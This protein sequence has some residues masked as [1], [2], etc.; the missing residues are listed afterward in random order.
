MSAIAPDG[1]P[2][3]LYALLPER[4]EGELVAQAVARGA[5]ILELGCGTGRITRQL[6]ARGLRVVAVDESAEMLQH[7]VGVETVRA[8]IAGL[9]LARR[10][11]A[12][13]LAS[14][15]VNTESPA[16]RRAFLETCARHAPV[17]I[18]ERLPADWSPSGERARLG[19]LDSWVEDATRDGDVVRGAVVYEASDGRAWRHPFAMRVLADGAFEGALAEAGLRVER[20]L[21]ERGCWVLARRVG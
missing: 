14:N 16:R 13:L 5:S 3:E 12:A 9:D 2:V 17:T 7:V 4:G 10:F 6:V 8:D 20:F 18:V 21:D 11:D 1:S 15:L 19:D